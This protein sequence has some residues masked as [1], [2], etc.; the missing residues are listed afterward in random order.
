MIIEW[1]LKYFHKKRVQEIWDEYYKELALI[2]EKYK[3][4]EKVFCD[5]CSSKLTNDK[6]YCALCGTAI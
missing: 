3:K 2:K 1:I 6:G 5:Y 4:Q